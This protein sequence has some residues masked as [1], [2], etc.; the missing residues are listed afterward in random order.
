VNG[1]QSTTLTTAHPRRSRRWIA[2]VVIV[3]ALAAYF[4]SPYFSFWRFSQALR[5]GDRDAVAAHVDF[6][7]LRESMKRELR[8][9][10]Y[11][12]NDVKPK[13]KDRLRQFLQGMAPSIIDTLV[14]AYITPDG[15]A[16]LLADPH[17]SLN[18]RPESVGASMG[19]GRYNI[20]WSKA[21]RAYFT[22]PRDFLVDVNGT[23]LRF[24]FHGTG[25]LLHEIDLPLDDV[26]PAT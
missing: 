3:A 12:E 14:D 17:I 9:H 23:K 19:G 1:E 26:A 5:D 25:W 2:I 16:A 15:L 18:T 21:R 22:G 20:D 4:V 11:P 6:P 10:F 24:R 8:A 7:E 13:K